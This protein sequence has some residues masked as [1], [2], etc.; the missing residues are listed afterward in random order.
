MSWIPDLRAT[1]RSAIDR[2]AFAVAILLTLGIGT[3]AA[4]S[5][6]AIVDAVLIRPLPFP[7]SDR[8]AGV[9]FAS[10]DFPGGLDRV[11]QSKATYVHFR[12]GSRT[13]AAF[14]LAE[15]TAVTLDDAVGFRPASIDATVATATTNSEPS[16]SRQTEMR[17]GQAVLPAMPATAMAG[18]PIRTPGPGPTPRDHVSPR[19]PPGSSHC[20]SRSGLR[21]S[22]P[23]PR[24]PSRTLPRRQPVSPR[25]R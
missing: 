14:G 8:I 15:E 5:V 19:G 24:I 23:L 4:A 3:G 20:R 7:E 18:P 10:P 9:W 25:R 12:D 17:D 13:F 22:G 1:L 16:G 6:F 2:P 11:R 21:G